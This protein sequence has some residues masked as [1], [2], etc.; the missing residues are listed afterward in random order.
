M[1]RGDIQL[2]MNGSAGVLIGFERWHDVPIPRYN[3]QIAQRVKEPPEGGL[4]R[5]RLRLDSALLDAEVAAVL[6][7]G[8][9]SFHALQARSPGG[10]VPT[11]GS[12]VGARSLNTARGSRAAFGLE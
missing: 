9:T 2:E 7:D 5:K 11:A 3:P 1:D 4:G 6:P 10:V 12:C 8:R